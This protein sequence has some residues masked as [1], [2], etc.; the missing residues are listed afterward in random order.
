MGFLMRNNGD[1]V[2]CSLFY[3]VQICDLG[4]VEIVHKMI[5]PDLAKCVWVKNMNMLCWYLSLFGYI[6]TPWFL[7][8]RSYQSFD[9]KIVVA[10]DERGDEQIAPDIHL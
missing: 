7:W 10:I 9:K 1:N 4:E 8:P 5:Y 6:H 3:F 2:S